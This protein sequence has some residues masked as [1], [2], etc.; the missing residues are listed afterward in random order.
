MK[1]Y[2]FIIMKME[3]LRDSSAN[4]GHSRM[5]R[6]PTE[7]YRKC[8]I[9]DVSIK[10]GVVCDGASAS[11]IFSASLPGIAGTDFFNRF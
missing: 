10:H 8:F 2:K 11:N 5:I 4:Y 9:T 6:R 3:Q 7:D 1:P